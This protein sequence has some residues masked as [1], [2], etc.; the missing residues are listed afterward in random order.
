VVIAAAIFCQLQYLN[1]HGIE[2]EPR[3]DVREELSIVMSSAHVSNQDH[4]HQSTRHT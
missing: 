2:E 1:I 3:I 4:D